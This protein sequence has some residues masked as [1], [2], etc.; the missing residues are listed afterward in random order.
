MA[1][2]LT[3]G[4][5]TN[6]KD[7]VGGIVRAWMTNFGLISTFTI[8]A[9]DQITNASGTAVFYQYDLKNAG[10]TMVTTAT[11]S[12]D[13]GTNYFSTVLT[14]VLPKLT[15]EMSVETKLIAYGRPHII[16]EDR[17]SNF[18]WLGRVHGNELTSATIATGGAMADLTGYTL[19][20]TSE[21]V[22]PPMFISGGTAA[23][24]V[25]GLS[26]VTETITVGTNS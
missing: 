17:N 2:N 16:V 12:R 14:L 21:E 9:N 18:F 1:C 10:N 5:A 23:N 3:K 8:D 11:N 22:E 13:S 6:C 4:Y 19:E 7:V 20:F 24:P 15:K 26:G 25:A